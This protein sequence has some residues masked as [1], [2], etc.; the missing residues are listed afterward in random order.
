M[1]KLRTDI[2]E[3]EID[4]GITLGR[5]VNGVPFLVFGGRRDI[6]DEDFLFVEKLLSAVTTKLMM[7]IIPDELV[8]SE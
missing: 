7:S 3:D 5:D 2:S 6:T 1:V 4:F 8:A